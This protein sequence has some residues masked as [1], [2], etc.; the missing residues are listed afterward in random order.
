MNHIY[1]HEDYLFDCKTKLPS[2]VEI[3][4]LVNITKDFP[5]ALVESAEFVEEFK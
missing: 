2:A 1:N 4:G 5:R 3:L